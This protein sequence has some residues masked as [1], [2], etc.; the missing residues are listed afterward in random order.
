[1][2]GGWRLKTSG[3]RGSN[4]V[5]LLKQT[6]VLV[7]ERLAA[8]PKVIFFRTHSLGPCL[9]TLTSELVNLPLHLRRQLHLVFYEAMHSKA[10]VLP[11]MTLGTSR[12]GEGSVCAARSL[13]AKPSSCSTLA[14]WYM[15][16][17]RLVEWYRRLCGILGLPRLLRRDGPIG[18][19]RSRAPLP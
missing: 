10:E 8:A 5:Q 7:L 12:T 4:R 11:T 18:I 1:M 16:R 19:H 13:T 2:A 6:A 14:S 9:V 15:L 17:R 3:G